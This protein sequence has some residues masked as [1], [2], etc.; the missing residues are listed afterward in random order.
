MHLLVLRVATIPI[1]LQIM[2]W[3]NYRKKKLKPKKWRKLRTTDL[4]GT[5]ISPKNLSVLQHEWNNNCMNVYVLE[6]SRSLR[7]IIFFFSMTAASDGSTDKI[8]RSQ[9]NSTVWRGCEPEKF[10]IWLMINCW[11]GLLIWLRPFL[12]GDQALNYIWYYHCRI[13]STTSCC[14]ADMSLFFQS[15]CIYLTCSYK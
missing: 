1:R 15:F 3:K 6:S 4:E 2:E 14:G 13:A 11:L 8:F 10:C 9:L 5:F 7:S 12:S